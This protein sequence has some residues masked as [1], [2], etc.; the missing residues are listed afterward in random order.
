MTPDVA[1]LFREVADLTAE[2][3]QDYYVRGQ[4]PEALRAEIESLL[5]YD[6]AGDS[7]L[8]GYVA[9]AER[10]LVEATSPATQPQPQPTR[11]GGV[12][13]QAI[14]RFA[15]TRLLGRGGMGEVYLARDPLIDRPVAIKL[16]GAEREDEAGR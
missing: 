15:V 12:V 13:P 2:E 11:A 4:V 16:I 6:L 10:L 9:S 14:G 5:Q 3:R 8:H 7:S 1:A